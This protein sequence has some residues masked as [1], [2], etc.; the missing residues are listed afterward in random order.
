M[1]GGAAVSA[2]EAHLGYWLRVVAYHVSH[3]CFLKLA[4]EDVTV[5]EWVV[6]RELYEPTAVAPSELATRL[7]MTRGAA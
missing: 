2:M 7:G 1:S 4:A 5:A 3:S 6:L